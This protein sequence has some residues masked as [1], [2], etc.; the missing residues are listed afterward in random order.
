MGNE[1]LLQFWPW[2]FLN[3]LCYIHTSAIS[4]HDS[5][6]TEPSVFLMK[7]GASPV[8]DSF[9]MLMA[10]AAEWAVILGPLLM[11]PRPLTVW[12][13]LLSAHLLSRSPEHPGEQ[14][15]DW[16]GPTLTLTTTPTHT[17]RDHHYHT[18]LPLSPDPWQYGGKALIVSP[19]DTT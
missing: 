3:L 9:H 13:R 16:C 7:G 4:A 14:A 17:H 2:L 19:I 8:L 6:T 12:L 5:A 10:A 18:P 11:W 15:T 1:T